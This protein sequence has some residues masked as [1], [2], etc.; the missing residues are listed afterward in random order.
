MFMESEKFLNIKREDSGKIKT[1]REKMIEMGIITP[2]EPEKS[3]NLQEENIDVDKII[4]E[5]ESSE[6]QPDNVK[7]ELKQEAKEIKKEKFSFNKEE[8]LTLYRLLRGKGESAAEIPADFELPPEIEENAADFFK[9]RSRYIEEWDKH[10]RA[11]KTLEKS[12]GKEGDVEY[13]DAQRY[14]ENANVSYKL[15]LERLKR[16]V[17]GYKYREKIKEF[18]EAVAKIGKKKEYAAASA[19]VMVG[20]AKF[21]NDDLEKM[22]IERI[23]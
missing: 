12:G 20:I 15:A 11:L 19:S 21:I 17:V 18:P 23:S 5:S 6:I 8:N 13:V 10:R 9:I 4:K 14:L 2:K 7:E 22:K 16:D 1:E 3:N